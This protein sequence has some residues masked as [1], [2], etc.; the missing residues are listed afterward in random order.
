MYVLGGSG[1]SADVLYAPINSN[2]TIGAWAPTNSMTNGRFYFSALVY[3][4]YLYVVGGSGSGGYLSDVEYAPINPDG[5]LGSWS[6]ASSFDTPRNS[7]TSVIYNGYLYV[8]GGYNGS[9]LND[10]QYAPMIGNGGIGDWSTTDSFTTA[11]RSHTSIVHNGYIYV[12]G[13][14]DGSNYLND[15]RYAQINTG[16]T[17]GTGA[18]ASTS[19]L[20]TTRVG[21]TSVAHNGYLYAIGGLTNLVQYAPIN[22]SGTIGSWAATTSLSDNLWFHTSVVH[23]DYLYVIGGYNGS[24]AFDHVYYAPINSDGTIGSWSST[25][26]LTTARSGHSSVVYNSFLYVIGGTGGSVLNDVQFAPINSDGTIGS[27]SSTTSLTTARS[28]HTSIAYNGYLYVLG[29]NS[30]SSYFNDVQFAP[31]NS[32][33]AIGNWVTTDSFQTGRYLHASV[34]HNGHLYIIGGSVASSTYFNDVQFAPINSSGAIGP[35]STTT[36]FATA[37]NG[38]TAIVYNDYLY[39]LGGQSGVYAYRDDVQYAPINSPPATASYSKLIDLESPRE[40]SSLSFTGSG[41]GNY[42]LQYRLA[43]STSFGTE[44]VISNAKSGID[45][46]LDSGARYVWVRLTIDDSQTV[47]YPDVIG[48]TIDS[49]TLNYGTA[50]PDPDLRLR[51]GAYFKDGVKQPMDTTAPGAGGGGACG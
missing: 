23:N 14:Y 2:G 12:I 17:R 33:G 5:T 3:S 31:I 44:T 1:S 47:T 49:I 32:N 39:V 38:H 51:L 10:V 4:G 35:W 30:G 41:N 43:C 15:V 25:T 42:T 7:H 8:I 16:H 6:T 45:Y 28:Y 40:L 36:S 24:S 22:S 18:Y 46:P 26:S 27:W 11:R 29:G 50:H 19:S 34:V 21:H 9:Y 48:S 20:P 13:G 37:R